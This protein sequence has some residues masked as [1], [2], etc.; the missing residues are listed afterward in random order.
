MQINDP[1]PLTAEEQIILDEGTRKVTAYLEAE[2]A[3]FYRV[4]AASIKA[5]RDAVLKRNNENPVG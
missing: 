2:R 1:G 3:N 5:S 4:F